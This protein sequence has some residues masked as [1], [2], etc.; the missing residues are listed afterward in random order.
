[1]AV[2]LRLQ[3]L[4]DTIERAN[5][6]PCLSDTLR[7][8]I[9]QQLQSGVAGV[10]QLRA[11]FDAET[12]PMAIK[13]DLQQLFSG[14][15]IFAIVVPRGFSEMTVACQSNAVALFKSGLHG[16]QTA[17]E[18]A[19]KAGRDVT[20]DRQLFA[21]IQRQLGDAD[22]Q[23][24]KALTLLASV[25]PSPSSPVEDAMRTLGTV[26][27]EVLTVTQDL[28]AAR[29]DLAEITGLLSGKPQSPAE[30]PY[31]KPTPVPGTPS[32]KASPKA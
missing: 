10:Q 32:P 12:D 15:A 18:N 31:V 7:A 22:T 11:K 6:N 26:K 23:V 1:M 28:Q 27:S 3:A 4:N 29:H 14:L 16:V 20:Q 2:A 17:I 24:A 9:V 30:T 25:N 8:P 21:D 13:A 19:A 5:A